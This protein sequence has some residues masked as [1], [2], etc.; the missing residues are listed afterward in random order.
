MDSI[1]YKL[2]GTSGGPGDEEAERRKK[3]RE[4]L[5]KYYARNGL[6][7]ISNKNS[8]YG[9]IPK[10]SQSY[11]NNF[12]ANIYS[13]PLKV[14][15][16]KDFRLETLKNIKQRKVAANAPVLSNNKKAPQLK[17]D[18][19]QNKKYWEDVNKTLYG[20]A[21]V[22][23]Y[24]MTGVGSLSDFAKYLT[25]DSTK[26]SS[27]IKGIF[28]AGKSFLTKG[29]SKI[30]G[31]FLAGK[32]FLT[33]GL[34]KIK[35]TFPKKITDNIIGA[36]LAGK[37]FLTKDLSKFKGIFSKKLIDNFIGVGGASNHLGRTVNLIKILT[38]KKGDRLKEAV[39][40]VGGNVGAKFATNL[41]S[42]LVG[43]LITGRLI[44]RYAGGALGG[45]IGGPAG[46]MLGSI[47]GSYVGGKL[48]GW[49]F[50]KTGLNEVSKKAFERLKQNF[51]KT[52][53]K[54]FEKSGDLKKVSARLLQRIAIP[55]KN[56]GA[57]RLA[58]KSSDVKL[59]VPSDAV[60]KNLTEGSY[61]NNNSQVKQ[62]LSVNVTVNSQADAGGLGDE[63][64]SKIARE[65]RKA[66]QNRGGGIG[67][68]YA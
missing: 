13:D 24:F 1:N 3:A 31:I 30:K 48:A 2:N 18:A 16:Y 52:G 22:M 57:T 28:L 21:N 53:E 45:L 36:G 17:K 65:L 51:K 62:N 7:K 59:P 34:S 43:R 49:A 41:T 9:R 42:R 58:Y 68:A 5:R 23:S 55:V 38:T 6:S 11:F 8:V 20:A 56:T 4:L 44:G 63:I 25:Q 37:S 14:Y 19:G 47:V 10:T 54:A 39:S 29:S 64:A 26:G 33:K 12:N 60:Y 35:G 50:E 32:S 27:K 15:P 40:I 67:H 46:A 61:T 66:Y